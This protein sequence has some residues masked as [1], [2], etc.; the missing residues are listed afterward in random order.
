MARSMMRKMLQWWLIGTSLLGAWSASA[1][2][3]LFREHLPPPTNFSFMYLNQYRADWVFTGG[4]W[5]ET[6]Q[7]DGVQNRFRVLTTR[8]VVEGDVGFIV[9]RLNDASRMQVFIPRSGPTRHR[10]RFRLPG[11]PWKYI[12]D[13][14]PN[15]PP[16]LTAFSF[17]YLNQH[18]GNWV[19]T[20]DEWV[21]TKQ[22]DG[23]QSRFRVLT[24]KTVVEGDVGSIVER[25]NDASRMQV[26][27]PYSGP[28]RYRLRFRLPGEP[29]KYTGDI[30]PSS[31]RAE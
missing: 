12:G 18:R 9:E 15:G 31:T 22:E 14:R 26:F 2:E 3:P 8:T 11:E 7:E 10:L 30:L 28:T 6:K 1:D 24:A 25:L 27:I 19:F 23:V 4:E 5:V 29:W 17:M 21:E 20:N 16:P 13:I